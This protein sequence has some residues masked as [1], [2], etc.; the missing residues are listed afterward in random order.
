[1]YYSCKMTLRYRTN[2]EDKIRIFDK[3]TT[4]K[5]HCFVE[6]IVEII[7]VDKSESSSE[8][9]NKEYVTT[10]LYFVSLPCQ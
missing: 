4:C 6:H 9:H 2:Q 7:V 5:L 1:M 10:Y 3:E 8:F